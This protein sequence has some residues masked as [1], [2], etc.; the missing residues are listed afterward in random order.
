MF[1]SKSLDTFLAKFTSADLV[2]ICLL[3]TSK[4]SC[5]L[6]PL[7]RSFDAALSKNLSILL[8]E[9]LNSLP[10]CDNCFMVE[11]TPPIRPV[12]NAPSVPNL[13]LF[14]NSLFGS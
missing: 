11:P 3:S 4:N 1:L 12:N 9:N 5:V 14:I 10:L 8:L 7:A 13:I 2:P 6:P